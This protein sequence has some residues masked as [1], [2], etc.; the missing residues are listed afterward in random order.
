MA[1][2][3]AALGEGFIE[4]RTRSLATIYLTRRD[5]L[6]VTE[7]D[8]EAID[9]KVVVK[10]RKEGTG[11]KFG[12][13][14]RGIKNDVS[15]DQA[16]A[17]LHPTMEALSTRAFP[18]PVCLFFFRMEN[19]EGFVTWVSEPVVTGEGNPHLE[20]RTEASCEPLDTDAINRLVG[21]VSAWYDAF[22]ANVV[23][24]RK[25]HRRNGIE[26]LHAII[27]GE[28]AYF[29]D[30]GRPPALLKLTVAEAYELAKLGR[31][32]LGDLAGQIIKDGIRV[33]EKIGLLGVTVKLVTDQQTFSFE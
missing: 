24:T 9:L 25:G 16:N 18:F 1:K 17:I 31:E 30:H 6:I 12:V 8:E 28:A 10:S 33:L 23:G 4:Q 19:D 11:R 29:S 21:E 22:S 2:Q 7:S 14:L 3:L 13:V 26:L 32:H 27:D 20:H 5:D 15:A